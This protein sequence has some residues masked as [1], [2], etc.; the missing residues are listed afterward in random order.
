MTIVLCTFFASSALAQAPNRSATPVAHHESA[1]YQK[2]LDEDVRWIIAGDE[3][4]AFQQLST[5]EERDHFVDQFWSRRNPTPGAENK[6]KEEH[7][8]RLAYAN[9][10]FAARRP[11]WRTDR[12]HIYILYGPPSRI[13]NR[14]FVDNNGKKYPQVRWHY[15]ALLGFSGAVDM[16]FVDGCACGDYELQLSEDLRN[17]FLNIAKPF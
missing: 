2:W 17:Q 15:D 8:R 14:L 4:K 9:E 3:K 12:G 5:D 16:D 10:H 13:E 6:F 1:A 7:Y 11:G